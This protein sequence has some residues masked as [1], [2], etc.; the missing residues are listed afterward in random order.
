MT[1]VTICP[2][3]DSNL[4]RLVKV[5]FGIYLTDYPRKQ[6]DPKTKDPIGKVNEDQEPSSGYSN[7]HYPPSTIPS[8]HPLVHCLP[9]E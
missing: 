7:V 3:G 2:L 4:A 5:P 1:K 9:P 8:I 6:G